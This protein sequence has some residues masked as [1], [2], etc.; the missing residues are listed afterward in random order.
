FRTR[1]LHYLW[2][3]KPIITTGGDV[4][5]DEITANNAGIVVNNEAD[6]IMAIK[7]MYDSNHYATYL[8]GVKTL[9]EKYRW[10]VVT[11]PLLELCADPSLAPDMVIENNLR[12]SKAQDL[13]HE[14][15]ILKNRLEFVENSNSWRITEPLRTMRRFLSKS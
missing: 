9:A 15:N 7:K 2:A 4:L 13:K 6:W 14:Y 5:A 10:S 8:A 12:I 1:I 11:K 3:N